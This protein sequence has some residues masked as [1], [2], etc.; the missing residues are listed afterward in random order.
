MISRAPV[1]TVVEGVGAQLHST[2]RNDSAGE[3]MAMATGTNL[4]V[5]PLER[6]L[7]GG[8]DCIPGDCRGGK[9]RS[10][11]GPCS[12]MQKVPTGDH[13]LAPEH[14]VLPDKDTMKRGVKDHRPD[15]ILSVRSVMVC[16]KIRARCQ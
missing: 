15:R 13:S 2:E 14:D 12:T 9:T 7:L 5:D 4:E 8:S 11:K 6:I 10:G 16:S 1:P 3:T